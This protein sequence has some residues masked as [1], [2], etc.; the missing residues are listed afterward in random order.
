[1]YLF[2]CVR[3]KGAGWS[4]NWVAWNDRTIPWRNSPLVVQGLLIVEASLLHS[5]T[6]HLLGLLWTSYQPDAENS[7]W[8][9]T[10][11]QQTDI[12]A[13]GGIRSRNTN[14]Y[15]ALGRAANGNNDRIIN[16]VWNVKK[17]CALSYWKILCWNLFRTCGDFD[18][19]PLLILRFKPAIIWC[20]V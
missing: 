20:L 3:F 6:S 11:P 17:V 7:T 4:S 1:M 15:H 8:Q 18:F 5:D 9:N 16:A 13:S 19:D 14:K 2:I 12:H 10:T